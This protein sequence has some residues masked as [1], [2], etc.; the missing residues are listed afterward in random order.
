MTEQYPDG[1]HT[2]F[3]SE[4]GMVHQGVP[5]T[6][7]FQVP[8]PKARA[9]TKPTL[10]VLL[11]SLLVVG[12]TAL[13]ARALGQRAEQAQADLPLEMLNSFLDAAV[14]GDPEWQTYS[15]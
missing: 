14:A 11:V 5:P 8:A 3:G 2:S 13:G 7:G 10:V 6:G 4:Q 15:S 12:A 1:D 9:W